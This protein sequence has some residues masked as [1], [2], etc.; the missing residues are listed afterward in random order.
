MYMKLLTIDLN[1]LNYK[2]FFINSNIN[3][4]SNKTN[5]LKNIIYIKNSKE[6]NIKKII[7]ETET[8][9][10]Q[11]LSPSLF[12]GQKYNIYE[13][14]TYNMDNIEFDKLNLYLKDIHSYTIFNK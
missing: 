3:N 1:K 14:Y 5:E 2:L 6:Y 9:Y 11:P 8:F 10:Q 13:N 12:E 7:K 4:C